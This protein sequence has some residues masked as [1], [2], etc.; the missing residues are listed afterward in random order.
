MLALLLFFT[1]IC[2]YVLFNGW[3]VRS[4]LVYFIVALLKKDSIEFSFKY[5]YLPVV[6]LL[7]QDSFLYGRF[8][9]ALAYILPLTLFS[10]RFRNIL[11]ATEEVVVYL[12]V[13]GTI[14]F[15]NIFFKKMLL[16]RPFFDMGFLFEI[17]LNIII[18]K[19]VLLGMRGN[20]FL[21]NIFVPILFVLNLFGRGRKVWTPNRRNAL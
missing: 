16:M 8:G 7:L 5:F 20:R 19:V 2:A 15:D 21:P 11:M 13:V 3:Y 6:L 4:L 9:L 10:F 18:T 1:D 17:F 14:I 12:L